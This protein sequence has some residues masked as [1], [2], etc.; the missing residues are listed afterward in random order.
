MRGG[1]KVLKIQDTGVG[2]SKETLD[3]LFKVDQNAHTEGTSQEGGIG[4]GLILTKE[5]VKLNGGTLEVASEVGKGTTFTM[6]F[7]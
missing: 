2:M 4:L 7:G 3:K 5:L 1:Q 6:V